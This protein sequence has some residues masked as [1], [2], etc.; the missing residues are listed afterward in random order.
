MHIIIYIYTYFFVTQNDKESQKV[1]RHLADNSTRPITAKR[2]ITI[3]TS[4]H[5]AHHNIPLS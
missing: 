1:D 3:Y 4:A 2:H 5:K